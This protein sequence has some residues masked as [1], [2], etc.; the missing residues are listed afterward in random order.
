MQKFVKKEALD[1][2]IHSY[3]SLIEQLKQDK[4]FKSFQK[5]SEKL[6]QKYKISPA[7]LLEIEEKTAKIPSSVFIKELTCLEVICKYLKE[8][9]GLKNNEI[10]EL[11]K[12]S[13]KVIWQA[14]K[15]A[16]K[17]HPLLL[18]VEEPEFFLPVS[19]FDNAKLSIM[20][21]I[22]VYLKDTLNF[23]YHKIA[24]I[25]HRDDRTVWT[26]YQRAKKK[27]R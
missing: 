26:A 6:K 5:I 27:L 8:N 10:S 3:N 20:E 12:R 17:K 19:I 4:D 11:L 18:Y 1:S 7:D 25:I 22:A 24:I 21:A 14:Y 9:I 23:T 2:D 13:Q 15:N 16:K